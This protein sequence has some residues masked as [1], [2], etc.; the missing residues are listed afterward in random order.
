MHL[1]LSD[2]FLERLEKLDVTEGQCELFL[3][4][5]AWTRTCGYSEQGGRTGH[6]KMLIMIALVAAIV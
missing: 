4:R 1:L 5:L 2:Q 6:G 3:A